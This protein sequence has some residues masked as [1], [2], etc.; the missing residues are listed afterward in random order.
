MG[1]T[2]V[3]FVTWMSVPPPCSAQ[4]PCADREEEKG[5]AGHI[6]RPALEALRP[7]VGNRAAAPD[8]ARPHACDRDRVDDR[9]EPAESLGRLGEGPFELTRVQDVGAEPV[10][11][12]TAHRLERVV[13]LCDRSAR[14]ALGEGPI[15]DGA[16]EVPGAECDK[17]RH[18]RLPVRAV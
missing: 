2:D 15:E 5:L 6:R 12:A 9:I 17:G 3:A 4:R 10:R 7:G 8:V 13:A 1:R 18:Q 11:A 16:A 14:P